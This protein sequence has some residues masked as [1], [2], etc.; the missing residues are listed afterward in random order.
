[1]QYAQHHAQ[2]QHQQQHQQ[3]QQ[4]PLGMHQVNSTNSGAGSTGPAAMLAASAIKPINVPAPAFTPGPGLRFVLMIEGTVAMAGLWP[5]ARAFYVEP[6]LREMDR[7]KLG[8]VEFAV[9]VLRSREVACAAPVVECSG[10]LSTVSEVRRPP[11]TTFPPAAPI[12]QQ[13]TRNLSDPGRQRPTMLSAALPWRTGRAAP[14]SVCT[15]PRTAWR[16]GGGGSDA[17]VFSGTRP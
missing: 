2:P 5:D 8:P 10:W 12:A 14:G 1:M 17:Q 11:A 4:Q 16:S 13:Q 7:G 6:L 15:P 3:Q 9:Y